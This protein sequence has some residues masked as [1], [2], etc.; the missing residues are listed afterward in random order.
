MAKWFRL[1]GK[2]RGTRMS[3]SWVVG[4]LGE[5]AFFGG[6]VLL[7]IVSLTTV[8]TWQLFWPESNVFKVG[9]GF[10]LMV[11]A[12]SSFIV[13]G[14]T[15]FVLKVTRTLASPEKRSI[16]AKQAKQD[17]QRRAQPGGNLDEGCLPSVHTLTD[18]PGVKLTYRL[19][20]QTK[21]R[22][23]VTLSGLFALAWN[24]L[25]GVLLVIAGQNLLSGQTNW[26]LLALLVPFA[27]VGFYAGRWFFQLFRAHAGLG[28]MAV[29]VSDLP[30]LPGKVYQIYLCHYGRAEFSR[31]SLRLAGYEEAVYHQGTDIRTE[32]AQFAS[33][34]AVPLNYPKGDEPFSWRADPEDPLELLCEIRLPVDIM[35]SF[36][37]LNNTIRWKILVEGESPQWPT[38]CRSFPV[39]V[40]PHDER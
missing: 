21:D 23:S 16:L 35:H 39:V 25:V 11:I 18:S 9:L 12:S 3:G 4:R 20:D 29:E 17:H 7:G 2:K 37:G 38:F 10:W 22:L 8:V 14:L 24:S 33:Y 1:W 34:E 31:L 36:Q 13:L 32:A 15:G 27:A 19:P 30:L 5:A 6:L 28:A 26:F 40:Y